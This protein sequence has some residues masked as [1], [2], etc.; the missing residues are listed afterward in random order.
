MP[1]RN[2]IGDRC[3][4][5]AKQPWSGEVWGGGHSSVQQCHRQ[6]FAVKTG[7]TIL[8]W[9]GELSAKKKVKKCGVSNKPWD[10]TE[11]PTE[12][13]KGGAKHQPGRCS[14]GTSQKALSANQYEF[15]GDKRKQALKHQKHSE[16]K[17]GITPFSFMAYKFSPRATGNARQVL[18]LCISQRCR[19]HRITELFELKEALKTSSSKPLATSRDTFH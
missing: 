3:A 19:V 6:S 18:Y 2:G 14:P 11:L 13:S 9:M 7:N 8:Q 12:V 10:Q 1:V 16:P 4:L 17:V 15:E 5:C